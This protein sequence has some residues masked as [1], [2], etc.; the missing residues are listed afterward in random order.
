[1]KISS[2]AS[3]VLAAVL[4]GAL[5]MGLSACGGA[6]KSATAAK[7]TS[8]ANTITAQVA[9][10]G[11]DFSPATTSGALPLSANWHVTE[12]LYALDYSNYK[13]F[14]A[15]AKGDPEKVSDTEYTVTLRDGAKF[16]D[17]KD[18]T[19]DD[20]VKSYQRTTAEGSLYISMLDFIDSVTASGSNKVTFKLKKAFPMLK[21][22]L[23]LIQ[24]TPAA[25][26][27]EE[28]KKQ[29]VGSGPWKYTSITDQQIK[30]EK[31]DK[32]NG[33][34]PAQTASMILPVLQLCRAA[35]QMP[36]SLCLQQH[37]RPLNVPDRK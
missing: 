1:M 36:W 6:K 12:P 34:F 23:A 7:S 24:I 17:G 32:Y 37:S 33:Q 8:V 35:K 3:K 10:S 31:N 16:S 27:D 4:S 22:R 26:T 14:N 20:V 2:K 13:V 21:Q 5:L 29:P 19:A 9:Y 28:L 15:L 25:A 30:F 18:V 11:R